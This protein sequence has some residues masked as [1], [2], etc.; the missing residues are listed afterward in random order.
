MAG[1]PA[2][3]RVATHDGRR[4]ERQRR[5]T[6]L[7]HAD[8]DDPNWWVDG[9][10]V[11]DDF[12]PSDTFCPFLAQQMPG[13]VYTTTKRRGPGYYL[14]QP[15]G[16]TRWRQHLD[17]HIP[18]DEMA[19]DS[20]DMLPS[21]LAGDP[22]DNVKAEAALFANGAVQHV[23]EV[24]W[25]QH[26]DLYRTSAGLRKMHRIAEG[27]ADEWARWWMDTTCELAARRSGIT[28]GA[29]ATPTDEQ[30][31]AVRARMHH[32]ARSRHARAHGVLAAREVPVCLGAWEYLVQHHDGTRAWIAED[33]V[34]A[35]ASQ[36]DIVVPDVGRR[37]LRQ[38][39]KDARTHLRRPRHLREVLELHA[40][41]MG[42]RGDVWL[43]NVTE[44]AAQDPHAQTAVNEAMGIFLRHA[45]RS[46]DDDGR[47]AE[48]YN[49]AEVPAA[50]G[51]RGE[52]WDQHES[53]QTQT[54][55][56]GVEKTVGEGDSKRTER[57]AGQAPDDEVQPGEMARRAALADA[58]MGSATGP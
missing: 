38:G 43:R 27:E 12:I 14:D 11:C 22:E 45:R 30:L 37:A 4:A 57:C 16:G 46:A 25:D 36:G 54:L 3:M 9:E 7:L 13:Y 24:T 19:S 39:M 10:L 21:D 5:R 23:P 8:H 56:R 33:G 58:A 17:R 31:A 20:D 34:L 51:M 42:A 26:R 55:Y 52:A 28:A 40:E 53:L 48:A 1:T 32:K 6:A 29:A 18:D 50:E 47:S 2:P 41:R 15:P 49:L 35:A 44:G